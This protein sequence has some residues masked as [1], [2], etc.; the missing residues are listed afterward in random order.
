MNPPETPPNESATIV[1][2]RPMRAPSL[3]FVVAVLAIMAIVV[4]IVA[5]W[6]A[7]ITMAF[8]LAAALLMLPIVNALEQHGIRR[9]LGALIVV[10]SLLLCSWSSR[11]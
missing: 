5:A 1:G 8:A 10:T 3:P 9:S 6:S 2:F 4:V 7:L 11:C